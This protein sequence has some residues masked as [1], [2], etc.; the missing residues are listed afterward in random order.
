MDGIAEY[1]APVEWVPTSEARGTMAE[2]VLKAQ[3]MRAI[4]IVN[5]V[6]DGT[7][8]E[9]QPEGSGVVKKRI[10]MTATLEFFSCFFFN[11]DK[12]CFLFFEAENPD[13]YL[14][15]CDSICFFVV[16]SFI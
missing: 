12:L 16:F 9:V 15:H 10:A 3:E 4:V 2:H 1:E 6:P 7:E 5:Y 14:N 13:V 8:T 11:V